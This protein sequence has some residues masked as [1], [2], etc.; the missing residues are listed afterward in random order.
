MISSCEAKTGKVLIDAERLEDL[1]NVY[2]SPVG[3]S[4][5]VYLVG[6]NGAAIVIKNSDKLEI[7]ATNKLDES[8]DASPAI[9]GRELF[10]RGRESLY[11]IAEK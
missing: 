7:L 6:R 1:K 9:A 3:A 10:L 2:A 5:R 11:C 4:D 8:F